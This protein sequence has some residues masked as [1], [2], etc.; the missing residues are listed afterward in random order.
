MII[1]AVLGGSGF[2]GSRLVSRLLENGHRVRIFDK[3]PSRVHPALVTLGDVRDGEA[4]Q[5][6]LGARD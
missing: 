6:R 4:E 5:S 3:A 1:I 2:V